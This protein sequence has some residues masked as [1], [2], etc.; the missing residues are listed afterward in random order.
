MMVTTGGR[1]TSAS[2]VSATV[3]S[4]KSA[5][6]SSSRTAANP[7]SEAISSI[8]SKSRRWLMVTI[9]P[10]FLSAKPTIWVG[11]ILRICARSA[12]VMNS[13]TRTVVR[14]RCSAAARSASISS[15]PSSRRRPPRVGAP[16]MSR[17]VRL[18]LSATAPW[19]TRLP[20]L[21]P[22]RPPVRAAPP[23]GANG[24]PNGAEMPP[25]GA[26]GPRPRSRR[27]PPGAPGAPGRG[28]TPRGAPGVIGRGRGAPGV[29]GAS[30]RGPLAGGAGGVSGDAL[31][32][33]VGIAGVGRGGT[34]P[35]GA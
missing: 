27:G 31:A 17:M 23:G 4:P 21:P 35:A 3:S 33:G 30:G 9:K 5:P 6:Y 32:T 16:R 2:S 12:T 29:S 34:L 7:N 19:S 20:F 14:S 18:M 24:L 15:R 13:L 28:A 25:P 22:G 8:W 26:P 11:E 1:D 10:R